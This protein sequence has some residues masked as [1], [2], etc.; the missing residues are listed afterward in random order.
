MNGYFHRVTE[1]TPTRLWVNN[2]T[3]ADADAAIRAGAV[4]CTTNPTFSAVMLRSE[5]ERPR[6]LALI[7]SVLSRTADDHEAADLVQQA[8]VKGVME[9]F[10]PLHQN[11]PGI[12]GFVSIQGNPHRDENPGHIVGEALRYREL[13]ENFIAKI[14]ITRAGLD[15]IEILIGEGIPIIATEVF[16]ISQMIETCELY[17]RVSERTGC[18]PP[19][20]VTHISGI[21]DEYLMK[22]GRETGSNVPPQLLQQ[23]GCTIARRQ[24]RLMR[25]RNYPGILLGGGARGTHHFTE[26][27]GGEV[28][29]TLNWSTIKEILEADCAVVSRIEH[30][31]EEAVIEAL[32]A[33]LSDFRKAFVDDGLA[34]DEFAG[35]GP[36]QYFRGMF[37]KGWDTLLATIKERRTKG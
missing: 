25:E 5:S 12:E 31:A 26:L 34:V 29:V 36:L 20:Y 37:I 9:K 28:H 10:L 15:A 22:V 18:K 21:Y 24:Y 30:Q 19:F 1:Q 2:P 17:R 16:A 11:R 13:G 32:T 23:A 7:D 6:T 35:F 27:V 8:L 3:A 4:S 14:P 33:E